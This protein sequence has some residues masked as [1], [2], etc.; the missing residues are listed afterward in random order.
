VRHGVRFA[1]GPRCFGGASEA[2]LSFSF[3]TPDELRVAAA[4]LAAA[5]EEALAAARAG[6]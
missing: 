1:P 6:S 3:Y 5:V 2:R 4:R